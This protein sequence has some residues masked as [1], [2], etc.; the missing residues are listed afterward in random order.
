MAV[1]AFLGGEDRGPG[2]GFDTGC[3]KELG[4]GRGIKVVS[5]GDC[6]FEEKAQYNVGFQG[7]VVVNNKENRFVMAGMEG[8]GGKTT[9][10]KKEKVEKEMRQQHYPITVMVGAA[11]GDRIRNRVGKINIT[12]Q[13]NEDLFIKAPENTVGLKYAGIKD[14]TKFSK[15]RWPIVQ[16]ETSA[17]QVLGRKRNWGIRIVSS[18]EGPKS[19]YELFIIKVEWGGDG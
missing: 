15:D 6:T 18:E 11:D 14:Q 4:P 17:V 7:L 10:T 12:K 3:K 1:G 9:M 8:M 13:N 2:Q 5:R 16:T 19:N